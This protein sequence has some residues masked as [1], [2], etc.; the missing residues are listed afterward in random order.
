MAEVLDKCPHCGSFNV[1]SFGHRYS[2]TTGMR[3]QLFHCKDCNKHC[4]AVKS[5]VAPPKKS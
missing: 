2:K 5:E 4:S 3:K 1:I